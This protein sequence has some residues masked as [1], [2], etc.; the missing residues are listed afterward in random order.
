[1]TDQEFIPPPPQPPPALQ[2]SLDAPAQP[3][4]RDPGQPA[5]G[6][7]DVFL[8]TLFF[9]MALVV[10][11]EVVGLIARMSPSLRHASL[12]AL[13]KA[14]SKDARFAVSTQVVAYVLLLAAMA[15]AVMIRSGGAF[16][17][18]ISW[19]AP[20]RKKFWTAVAAG[21]ALAAFSTLAEGLLSRWI[22]QS[23]PMDDYFRDARS[24]YLVAGFGILVAPLVEELYFRG[25]LYPALARWTGVAPAIIVTS[26]GFALL[27][28]T[29][30]AHAV[31]PLL[32]I[33][34]VG[35]V[36]NIVRVRTASV[37][38]GVVVHMTYN[39]ILFLMTFISTG[40][41]RHFDKH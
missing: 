28:G 13:S 29:Q 24:A 17:K 18:T 8:V 1:M 33:F 37:A 4:V 23:V 19:N 10:V 32:I 30:L 26:A 3:P 36:L 14:L 20:D 21:C 16:W 41:F 5:W 39:F 15:T 27:H 22:P 40:G 35:A 6:L 9:L 11:S 12:E 2:P 31:V 7:L 25:F 38:T 34:T